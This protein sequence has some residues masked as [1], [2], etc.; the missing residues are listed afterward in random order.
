MSFKSRRK[1]LSHAEIDS[2]L[3]EIGS[4]IPSGHSISKSDKIQALNNNDENAPPTSISMEQSTVVNS[5]DDKAVIEP[6]LDAT[7][8]D[9]TLVREYCQVNPSAIQVIHMYANSINN[10]I[11]RIRFYFV[12][13]R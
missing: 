6:E 2:F 10:N 13:K 3:S 9:E 11:Y 8:S 5:N 7:L 1:T 12:G 4:G